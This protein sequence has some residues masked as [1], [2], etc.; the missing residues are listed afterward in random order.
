MDFAE[1]Q[2]EALGCTKCGLCHSRTQVVFGEGPLNAELFVV[3][4]APGF[5]EDKEGRPFRGASGMLL[6]GLL[7]SL[8]LGRER[9]YLTT[10]VK[11]RPPGSPPRPPRPSEVSACRPY[12]VTQL[13]AVDPKVVVALGDLASR[14]LTG[15]KEAVSRIRGR[16]IPLDGRYV[17]PTLSLLRALYTPADRAL[18]VSDFSRLPELLEAERPSTYD[19]LNVPRASAIERESLQPGLW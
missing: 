13:A 12:L 17:F 9:V 7:N 1:A 6:D 10:L 19:T 14:V 11:C 16:A 2:K 3:G 5:N 8:D 15:R 4:E 18:L